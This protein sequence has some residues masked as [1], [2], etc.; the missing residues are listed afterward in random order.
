MARCL[1]KTIKPS[2]VAVVGER[3][4]DVLVM[5]G[6]CA[7]AGVERF[8]HVHCTAAPQL[9]RAEERW[10]APPPRECHACTQLG[11]AHQVTNCLDRGLKCNC[12]RYL[13]LPHTI[14]PKM[15]LSRPCAGFHFA[16]LQ[17]A[18]VRHKR[19]RLTW[20]PDL[21]ERF[22][23][24]CAALGGI[25]RAQPNAIQKLMCV[26]GLLTSHIKSHLQK[27]RQE[28]GVT[29]IP[30]RD[31]LR[32]PPLARPC[33]TS[34]RGAHSDK[35]VSVCRSPAAG[36]AGSCSDDSCTRSHPHH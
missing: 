7:V 33:T 31:P 19:P 29:V 17:P 28:L 3:L 26:Q 22:E 9:M 15:H 27:V 20:T 35:H 10:C 1:A 24:A 13:L 34:L 36:P 4:H 21:H 2:H 11:T 8:G 6:H 30:P 32:D 18:S 23:K 16:Q 5:A 12:S 14:A 25:E